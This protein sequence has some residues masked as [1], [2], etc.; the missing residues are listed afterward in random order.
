MPIDIIDT[1]A[2]NLSNNPQGAIQAS[3]IP[4]AC[5]YGPNMLITKNGELLMTIEISIPDGK[6]NDIKK[7]IQ[8]VI[9]KLG[10]NQVAFW[11]HAIRQKK[12]RRNRYNHNNDFVNDLDRSWYKINEIS[13]VYQNQLYITV[14]HIGRT[15]K[16]SNL[17]ELIFSIVKKNQESYSGKYLT[18]SANSL[19]NIANK[20]IESI[21]DVD[22]KILGLVE[23]N[24]RIYSEILSF[25]DKII[26]FE[27]KSVLLPMMDVADYLSSGKTIKFNFNNYE[28]KSAN[29]STK[30]SAIFAIKNHME[31]PNSVTSRIFRL[32]Y[33]LIVT[34][35]AIFV[36]K[37][38]VMNKFN[39]Q[40]ENLQI[41][42][43]ENMYKYLSLDKIQD[44]QNMDNQLNC[45]CQSQTM[46]TIIADSEEKLEKAV[47][48]IITVFANLGIVIARQELRLEEYLWAKLPA[49]F[50]FL[51]KEKL[52]TT[53][54]LA[55]YTSIDNLSILYLERNVPWKIPVTFVPEIQKDFIAFNFHSQ[56]KSHTMIMG[57]SGIEV[58]VLT[59]FLVSMAM[60]FI[61][62]LFVIT[63]ENNHFFQ[64][65]LEAKNF[66]L[67]KDF[68][69]N[70]FLANPLMLEKTANN[71]GLVNFML[72]YILYEEGI[73]PNA[74]TY[75][76]IKSFLKCNYSLPLEERYF[77][78][79]IGILSEG[80]KFSD[81]IGKIK[82]WHSG[83]NKAF[84]FD[85][86]NITLLPNSGK[87]F[88]RFDIT[89]VAKDDKAMTA[90]MCYLMNMIY[91]SVTSS[92]NTEP[93][94]V[95]L[96]GSLW[97][98]TNAAKAYRNFWLTQMQKKNVV[99]IITSR[100]PAQACEGK[101][102]EEILPMMASKIYMPV[103]ELGNKYYD[104]C[105]L[106]Q[107]DKQYLS[108]MWSNLYNC[109][110]KQGPN[111]I[112]LE[113][114]LKKLS[115][116]RTLCGIPNFDY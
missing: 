65:Q 77:S 106:D 29:D 56:N 99:V 18:N 47:K 80:E 16:I 5:H 4:Y 42:K 85:N 103:Y 102:Y 95:V 114:N 55:S 79:I 111:K 63:V 39:H 101:C 67:S 93:S 21:S 64:N 37:D 43:D 2:S 112:P 11:I 91:L 17:K 51:S 104:L 48:N 52:L 35:T 41:S 58:T 36:N 68:N 115:Q 12:E 100:N 6:L 96:E 60:K 78:N 116:F 15:I 31:L 105:R 62:K 50:T 54:M 3:Q 87:S 90:I 88:Y 69:K 13:D 14:V 72:R 34:Q 49:N 57:P 86:Q 23:K 89:D 59:N 30:F 113:F 19:Q 97:K 22:L 28:V 75:E 94:I 74:N 46:L 1:I 84:L 24:N 108:T 38:K 83:G 40:I 71:V 109:L 32:P 10:N 25:V 7:S 73:A 9:S 53:N 44:I 76:F 33:Q 70:N 82:N 107:Q 8:E 26:D 45:Y 20:I 61:K 27:E 81:I 66:V 110:L 98:M 92:D